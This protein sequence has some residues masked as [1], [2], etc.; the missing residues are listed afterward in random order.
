[1]TWCLHA[2]FLPSAHLHGTLAMLAS[3]LLS[4]S[5]APAPAPAPLS[6]VQPASPAPPLSPSFS[7]SINSVSLSLDTL[8][9]VA[10]ACPPYPITLLFY[11][12]L[13]TYNDLYHCASYFR[14]GSGFF[15]HSS[16]GSLTIRTWSVWFSNE[17]VSSVWH[18]GMADDLKTFLE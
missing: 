17:S 11:F 16:V 6:S 8:S 15:P 2:H 10:T 5:S 13:S 7:S 9:Q 12:L 3:L 1:M 14:F 18:R 4:S